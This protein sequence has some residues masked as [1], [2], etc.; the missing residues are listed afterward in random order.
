MK[1]VNRDG[2]IVGLDENGNEVPVEFAEGKAESFDIEHTGTERLEFDRAN[3][4]QS[5]RQPEKSGF[6]ALRPYPHADNPIISADTHAD[7]DGAADPFIR[8]F[9]GQYALFFENYTG[10]GSELNIGY[11]TS[12]DGYNWTYQGFAI[13]AA[14]DLAYPISYRIDGDWYMLPTGVGS[15][16]VQ[17][18]YKADSWPDSWSL[19][20]EIDGSNEFGLSAVKDFTPF[21]WQPDGRWY[22]TVQ[23]SNNDQRLYYS[24]EGRQIAG[25]SWT[26]HPSSPINSPG[27]GRGTPLVDSEGVTIFDQPDVTELRLTNLS[28][29]TVDVAEGPRVVQGTNNGWRSD[30]M[31]HVDVL[32]PSI[33][34]GG[35]GLAVVDGYDGSAWSIG[36]YAISEQMPSFGKKWRS[37]D[38]AIPSASYTAISWDG[39]YRD[40]AG[41][42]V[43][44]DTQIAYNPPAQGEYRIRGQLY[45]RGSTNAPYRLGAEIRA[46][47]RTLAYVDTHAA[48]DD[49]AVVPFDV[50]AELDKDEGVQVRAYQDSGGSLDIRGGESLTYIEV[51]RV[52]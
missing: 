21:Y 5:P 8:Y 47:S 30:T 26:E 33:H 2:K 35:R 18:I 7:I 36:L 45:F 16:G 42:I 40:Y 44:S 12:P 3:Y 13:D 11:A 19:V 28:T 17:R 31:H 46:E 4:P 24:D 9:D 23:D 52:W 39:G 25:R 10:G 49:S 50:T 41:G 6:V 38:V 27:K 20:E 34:D 29:D 37:T 1:L 43:T 51:D 48:L 32:M 22:A 14:D 15:N